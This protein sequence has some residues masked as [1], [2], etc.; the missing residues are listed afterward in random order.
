MSTLAIKGLTRSIHYRHKSALRNRTVVTNQQ[1]D[2][3]AST[4]TSKQTSSKEI[5]NDSFLSDKCTTTFVKRTLCHTNS[6]HLGSPEIILNSQPL[7]DLLPPLTSSNEIDLQL[8]AIISIILRDFIQA[9]YNKLTPDH[10]FVDE[11]VHVIA[12]CTRGLE[13]RVR[14]VDLENLL[15]DKIPEVIIKHVESTRIAYRNGNDVDRR[16]DIYHVLNPHP[17]LSPVP[18]SHDDG[19]N[20]EQTG[21]EAAW[22]QIL[23]E[24]VLAL[25]LNPDDYR[26]PCLRIL[27][28]E[29]VSEMILG[30]VICEKMSQGWFIW[31]IIAKSLQSARERQDDAMKKTGQD[32][33][34]PAQNNVVDSFQRNV[35]AIWTV[36]ISWL[37]L[38]FTLGQNIFTALS[39]AISLPLRT[40]KNEQD[41]IPI[42]DMSIFKLPCIIFDLQTKM[43]WLT[44]LL[45]MIKYFLL[46]GPGNLAGIDARVDRFVRFILIKRS[47]LTR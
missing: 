43:P 9:W 44:G 34:I 41:K 24:K 2:K 1:H 29:I 14:Q 40:N 21:N 33:S 4:T 8:Y 45:S 6:S 38:L 46:Y 39:N 25:L 15:M 37:V 5:N 17:A 19:M 27:V 31:E 36:M 42:I 16:R 32:Q 47:S 10:E 11:V 20:R 28:Q 26:N 22:R 13:Q 18:S 30:N 35:H 3:I 12:H 7:Q 23:V